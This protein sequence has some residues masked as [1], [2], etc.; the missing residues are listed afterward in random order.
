MVYT[1][2]KREARTD[3]SM[4]ASWTSYHEQQLPLPFDS[5]DGA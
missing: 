4:Q 2:I 5:S 1:E 3:F